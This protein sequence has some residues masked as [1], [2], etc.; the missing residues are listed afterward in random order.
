MAFGHSASRE[1]SQASSPATPAA[2]LSI[3]EVDAHCS[4]CVVRKLCLPAGL[5]P[6]AMH[7]LEGVVSHRVRVKKR[8]SLYRAGEQ[9]AAL[10]AVRLGTLKTVVL[11]EDGREQIT[12]YHMAGDI[13]GLDGLGGDHYA[14]G[15]VALE[16]SEA[17]V[18]PF[19]RLDELAHDL[20]VLRHNLFRSIAHDIGRDQ[21][22]LLLLGS[23][24]AEERVSLFLLELAE[25]FRARGYSSSEFVLRMTREEIASYLGLKLETVSRVFSHLQE[26]GLIQIQGR[27]VKLLDAVALKQRVGQHG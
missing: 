2:V 8:D 16:D 26:E 4:S 1:L 7:Q 24:C 12:G 10:Y 22:M 6:E 18:L 9:F 13:I 3:R 19:N 27:A 5:S 25:A 23:R 14:S 21:N 11:T 20:P 17:C 15:A